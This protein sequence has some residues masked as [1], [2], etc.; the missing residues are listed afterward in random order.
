MAVVVAVDLAAA[1]VAETTTVVVVV[2]GDSPEVAA[3]QIPHMVAEVAHIISAQTKVIQVA[4]AQ[5]MERL[6]LIG[7]RFFSG[8]SGHAI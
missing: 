7:R 8:A 4:F 3:E 6:R 1:A 5:G 2:A